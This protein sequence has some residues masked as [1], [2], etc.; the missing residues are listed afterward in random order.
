MQP[1]VHGH[2]H[3][4]VCGLVCFLTWDGGVGWQVAWVGVWSE[5]G[6][7]CFSEDPRGAVFLVVSKE[8]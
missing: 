3:E 2:V 7:S 8:H 6:I 1:D 5:A 4:T